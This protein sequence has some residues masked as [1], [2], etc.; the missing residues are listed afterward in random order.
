MTYVI[1]VRL[2]VGPRMVFQ[3][4]S[5]ELQNSKLPF[6]LGHSCALNLS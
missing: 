1:K 4:R 6:L 2:E 5:A 3:C